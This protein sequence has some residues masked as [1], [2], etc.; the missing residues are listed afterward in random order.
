MTVGAPP[1]STTERLCAAAKRVRREIKC[2]KI[3]EKL[4]R[5]IKVRRGTYHSCQE[6]NIVEQIKVERLQK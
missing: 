3:K 4:K 5:I 2:K 6:R 1:S